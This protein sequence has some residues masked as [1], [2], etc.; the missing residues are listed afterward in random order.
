MNELIR[1]THIPELDQQKACR[2]ACK[3]PFSVKLEIS[4]LKKTH[5]HYLKTKNDDL[6]LVD[7]A[8]HIV[9]TYEVYSIVKNKSK[10]S[11]TYDLS[12]VKSGRSIYAA[13]IKTQ[14]KRP[15]FE[16][17]LNYKIEIIKMLEIDQLS[18]RKVSK[19]LSYQRKLSVSHTLV[20]QFYLEVK[21]DA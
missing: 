18:Y 17:M 11:K 5:F 19:H 3:Q 14:L 13:M 6:I 10:K 9:A 8:A 20:R 12:D 15:K 2:W 16:K 4:K 1:L 21:N 7:L